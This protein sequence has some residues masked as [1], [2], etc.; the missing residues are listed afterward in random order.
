[1]YRL[2]PRLGFI[3][4]L[5]AISITIYWKTL[6]YDFINYDDTNYVVLN[7]KLKAGLSL[8]GIK[9]AFTTNEMSNWHPLTWLSLMLD[10]ELYGLNAG[11][12]HLT[13]LLLHVLST[14]LLFLSLNRATSNL[15]Q[16]ALCACLFAIHPIN[17]ESVAWIAERKGT[18]STFF[19]SISLYIYMLYAKKP[20]VLKYVL[21][22][23]SVMLGLMSKQMLVTLPFLF[24]L[25][26]YWPLK[27]FSLPKVIIE[28][29]PLFILTAVFSI[30]AYYAQN[31]GGS[32]LSVENLPLLNRL[33]NAIS[34][35]SNYLLKIFY[36]DGLSIFYTMKPPI[37]L[38]TTVAFLS[39]LVLITLLSIKYASKMPYLLVGWLWYVGTLVPTIQLVQVGMHSMA[40]RYLYIPAIGIF[41]AVSWSLSRLRIVA[42]VLILVLSLLSI[43]QVSHWK[44]TLHIFK[45]SIDVDRN[46]YLA[47]TKLGELLA[48]N[49]NYEK[50][51]QLFD[52]TI[53]LKPNY[54]YAYYNKGLTLHKLGKFEE[55]IKEYKKALIISPKLSIVQNA[56]ED[57]YNGFGPSFKHKTK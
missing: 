23:I 36:P 11:G 9:W 57:A 54:P 47:Y 20:D 15:W 46:N 49:N 39:L 16:S 53:E 8:E 34:Y 44:N 29:I 41:I 50:A 45:H 6:G 33:L 22:L 56:M 1:M 38:F 17:V 25:L 31:K 4:F 52:A 32:L 12:F 13:S 40:D 19:W 26:D 35:Y 24:M 18:L 42:I 10:Y 55:A 2:T 48:S 3:A 43:K 21:L 28:K 51:I 27:R 7:D 30:I 5:I 14:I 37:D